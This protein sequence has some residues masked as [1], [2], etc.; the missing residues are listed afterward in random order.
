MSAS[1]PARGKLCEQTGVTEVTEA[2]LDP[3]IEFTASV[4][5]TSDGTEARPT[6]RRSSVQAPI[7]APN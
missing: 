7:P 1:S 5:T 6:A 4:E 3:A 2:A